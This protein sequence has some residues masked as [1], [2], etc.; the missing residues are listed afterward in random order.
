MWP[1]GGCMAARRWT[2]PSSATSIGWQCKRCASAPTLRAA[3]TPRLRGSRRGPPLTAPV[4]TLRAPP[5][6]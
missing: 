5:R 2:L 3:S 6:A 1:L 4:G